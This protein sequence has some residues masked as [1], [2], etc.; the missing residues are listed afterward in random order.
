MTSNDNQTK[1]IMENINNFKFLNILINDISSFTW[2]DPNYLD[3]LLNLDIYNTITTSSDN[4][5]ND[6]VKNLNFDD[7]I[8]L[9]HM[10]E[11]QVIAEY[12]EYIYEILYINNIKNDDKYK[13]DIGS[14]LMINGDK[15]YGN[16]I[17]LKTYLHNNSILFVDSTKDDIKNILENRIKTKVVIYEDNT[18][19][20]QIVIGNIEDFAK[21]FFDDIYFKI[22]KS[23]LKH[24]INIWYEKSTNNKSNTTCNNVL[25]TGDNVLNTCGNLLNTCGNLLNIPI[26]KCIWFTMLTDEIRGNLL[27]DEV[28]KI[29]KLSYKLEQ[30]YSVN[31]EWLIEEKDNYG[32]VKIKNKYKILEKACQE[33]NI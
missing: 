30:P 14:L 7:G 12:P 1:I 3:K 2:L 26:S 13:N 17:I 22:E 25:N 28:T 18:W 33:K 11:T 24:N 10:I 32:R 20:E 5:L 16:I 29:I 8:N 21:D 19:N 31:P 15:I 4:F 6:I 23:F 9:N 27:L